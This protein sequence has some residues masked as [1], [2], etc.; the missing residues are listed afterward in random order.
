MFTIETERL[1]L[2]DMVPK[3]EAAFVA[4]SQHKKYQRFYSE[5]DCDPRKYKDLT[6]LFI[7]QAKEEPRKEYQLAIV[8][9]LTGEFIG[10]ACLRLESNNQ[11]SMGCGLSRSFQG[12]RLIYEAAS[13]LANFGFKE[14]NI[15]RIYAETISENKAA[16][17]LCEKLGMRH[18]ALFKEHRYFKGRWWNTTVLAM[19]Y[20]EFKNKA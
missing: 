10:T 6:K 8:Y 2:R 11:A 9:K 16:I 20:N 13:A 1:I 4:I 19:L 18:E 15:H 14:L 5:D 17:K 7:R 12:S 3:D